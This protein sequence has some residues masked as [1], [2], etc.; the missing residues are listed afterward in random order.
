M[1]KCLESLIPQARK[2]NI[3]IYV[4]DNASTDNTTE[5]LDHFKK[6]Y[7]YLYSKTNSK[8][9]G[10]DKNMVSA[11]HMA[12]SRYVWALGARRIILPGVVDKIYNILNQN[13]LDL[14][15]LNDL[16]PTF[17]APKSDTYSSAHDI[18]RELNR[19]LT[20]LGFQIL[21]LEA[22]KT[23]VAEKYAE[24]DW[25]VFGVALEYIAN[26]NNLNAFFLSEPIATAS[27]ESKWIPRTFQIWTSWKKVI[28]SLPYFYSDAEKECVIQKSVNYFFG[29]RGFNLIDRRAQGIYNS[30]IF[31]AYR[32]DLVHYGKLSPTFA[33]VVSKFPTLPLKLYGRLYAALRTIARIFIHQN[34]ALNPNTRRAKR[35]TYA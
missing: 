8:N 12:S 20:G 5:M 17:S 23:E 34:A 11:V 2:Y 16:N 6:N 15:I 35:I 18:F 31:E 30:K 3:P 29:G 24:T 1:K 4:S 21:P 9:M 7:P 10:V 32:E 27:G 26:K 14:L 28:N 25:T 33:Y 22:W 13:T 19:N